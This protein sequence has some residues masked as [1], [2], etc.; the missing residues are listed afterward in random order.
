LKQSSI[1]RFYKIPQTRNFAGG[2]NIAGLAGAMST[3]SSMGDR[4]INTKTLCDLIGSKYYPNN[5]EIEMS[6]DKVV[7][8][9]DEND[10]ILGE[11]TLREAKMAA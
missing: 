7:K 3:S 2:F 11:M 9:F 8:C 1:N 6:D 5:D 4:K 10:A